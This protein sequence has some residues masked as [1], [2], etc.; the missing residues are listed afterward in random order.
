MAYF[1]YN[2]KSIFYKELGQGRPV[3]FLHGNTASSKM[4]ELLMPLYTDHFRCILIDFLGNGRSDRVATFQPDM[5]HD[6][7]MQTVALVEH[8]KGE[9]ATLI[10]TSGG[11]WAALNA[12]LER[13]DLFDKVIADSFDGRTLDD[14]FSENLLAERRMAKDN[15]LSRQFYEWC[16]GADWEKVVDLDTAA[17]VQCHQEKRPLFGRPLTEMK[18]PVLLMGSKEDTMCRKDLEEEYKAMAALL[19]DPTIHLFEQG[20]HPAIA[21]NAEAAA[22]VITQFIRCPSTP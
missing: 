16:Q 2:G 9:R 4:F 12:V 15:P 11:A 19:P 6:E 3:V 20:E 7:A 8:L 1:D 14:D 13:P 17:L 22:K 5:W 10:G 21:T 18:R